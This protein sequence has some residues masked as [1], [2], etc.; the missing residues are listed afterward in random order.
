MKSYVYIVD[1]H[2][3]PKYW[4]GFEPGPPKWEADYWLPG[5]L[6]GLLNS[7]VIII[8]NH[9]SISSNA[10][11]NHLPIASNATNNHLPIA[12]NAINNH[13]PFASNAINNHL[14]IASN[15][16]NNHL[17]ITSNYITIT[18]PSH[19]TLLTITFPL[20]QTLLTITFPSLQT[21]LT[22]TFPSLQTLLTV[23]FPSH[24]TVFHLLP[25]DYRCRA[26]DQLSFPCQSLP[27]QHS[28][29]PS[30]FIRRQ[31]AFVTKPYHSLLWTSVYALQCLVLQWRHCCGPQRSTPGALLDCSVLPYSPN[32][33]STA[34]TGATFAR[35]TLSNLSPLGYAAV[36]A[37]STETMKAVSETCVRLYQTSRRHI[38][39]DRKLY[40][41]HRD[42]DVEY[43]YGF[44]MLGGL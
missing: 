38:P 30:Q 2:K 22:V 1:V 14:P 6:H 18:F 28:L 37:G 40:S 20:L 39:E 44:V 31:S 17:P 35:D 26:E 4:T 13:L 29:R 27:L 19:Q 33:S 21:L 42:F 8:H 5:K 15:A 10:F 3:S 7:Y 24:Q 23:T 34:D 9:R 11:N 36:H 16:I 12:S 25:E 41:H 32:P 43:I